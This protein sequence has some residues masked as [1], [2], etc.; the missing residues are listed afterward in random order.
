MKTKL[1]FAPFIFGS[2]MMLSAVSPIFGNL[3]ISAG[4][5]SNY[6]PIDLTAAPLGAG[7]PYNFTG[8][9]IHFGTGDDQGIVQG[10]VT[11][12]HATPGTISGP[13]YTGKYLAAGPA[14]IAITFDT[15]QKSFALLWGSVSGD[16][17]LSFY[18]D[19]DLLGTVTGP[20]IAA[21]GGNGFTITSDTA[22]DTVFFRNGGY[23]FEAVP[24]ETTATPEPGFYGVIGLGFSVLSF[25]GLRRRKASTTKS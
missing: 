13:E 17:E 8:G 25:A 19:S 10:D 14:P 22:F 9:T 1:V 24:F 2:L 6:V 18:M 4:I 15:P 21:V 23:A 7:S 11:G 16:N 20:E 5:S 12:A 3:T